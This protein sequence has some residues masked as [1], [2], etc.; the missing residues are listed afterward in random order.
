VGAPEGS[1]VGPVKNKIFKYIL[2]TSSYLMSVVHYQPVVG[3]RVGNRV[4]VR[5][6]R[7]V[8]PKIKLYHI[9]NLL[10]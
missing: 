10:K 1:K 5:V 4:G 3:F 2:Y 7:A 8:G 9:Y 6:G